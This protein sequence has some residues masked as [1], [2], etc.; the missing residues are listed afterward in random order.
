MPRST[1]QRSAWG[2]GALVL[3]PAL[4]GAL[5]SG[6]LGLTT[7]QEQYRATGVV[8]LSEI[9]GN[10]ASGQLN[11]YAADLAT[12]LN[13]APVNQEVRQALPPGAEASGIE[14]DRRSDA[15]RVSI[16]LQADT[17]EQART[18]LL[19][20]GRAGYLALVEQ[21]AQ[22][23]EVRQRAALSRLDT[24]A[25]Y[26]ATARA[27]LDAAPPAGEDA[28]TS[29]LEQNERLLSIALDDLSRVQG[30]LALV[31]ELR[32]GAQ[33]TTA[34]TVDA[35]E[36]V[37]RLPQVLP[38][39][40]AGFVGGAIPGLALALLLRRRGHGDGGRA[41]G[42]RSGDPRAQEQLPQRGRRR[43]EDTATE[44]PE[45]PDGRREP[46]GEVTAH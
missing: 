46:I 35:V 3:V 8:Q 7:V 39:F 4:L 42:S 5:V 40:A 6:V 43:P 22:L 23:L 9:A 15:S 36:P 41:A 17:E 34:V 25:E 29:V 28:A 20:G 24:L 26:V 19:A 45:A 2:T 33:T 37:S 31:E 30:Q 38:I 18:A 12:A 10:S 32:A 11:P 13:S 1:E 21:Q 44:G 14:V 16:S 27:A